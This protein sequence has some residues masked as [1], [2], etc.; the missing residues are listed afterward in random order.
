MMRGIEGKKGWCC[1]DVLK[2]TALQNA[3]GGQLS[4]GGGLTEDTSAT[5]L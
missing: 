1:L 3:A 2:H 4:E 5:L